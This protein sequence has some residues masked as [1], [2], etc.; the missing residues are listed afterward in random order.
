MKRNLF[1]YEF[2]G[3]VNVSIVFLVCLI[4]Y[5]KKGDIYGLGLHFYYISQSGNK[6]LGAVIILGTRVVAQPQG[7]FLAH[8]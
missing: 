7:V 4:P 6:R 2:L 5:V 8:S 1:N 3:I